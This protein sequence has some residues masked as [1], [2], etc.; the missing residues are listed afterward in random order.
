MSQLR[1]QRQQAD[2]LYGRAKYRPFDSHFLMQNGAAVTG[3]IDPDAYRFPRF[4]RAANLRNYACEDITTN[5]NEAAIRLWRLPRYVTTLN[6]DA[7]SNARDFN[8]DLEKKE[9]PT[10]VFQDHDLNVLLRDLNDSYEFSVHMEM[11]RDLGF[12]GAFPNI[13][14]ISTPT[15]DYIVDVLKIWD[16]VQLLR[17]FFEDPT[18]LKIFYDADRNLLILQKFFGIFTVAHIDIKV[19]HYVRMD[20]KIY[21]YVIL[22]DLIKL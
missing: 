21:R 9:K 14:Q 2:R 10:F 5:P 6:M 8:P 18:K 19:V 12:F 22:E 3:V 4:R 7:V 11:S 16:K 13:M 1:W 15:N 20:S 17:P